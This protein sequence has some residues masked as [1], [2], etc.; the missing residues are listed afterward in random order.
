MIPTRTVPVVDQYHGVEVPDPYRW[1]EDADSPEVGAWIA[2]QNQQ[3]DGWIAARPTRDALR[4]ELA[5]TWNYPRWS[6]PWR[7]GGRTFFF[8]NDGLQN[9][10]VLYVEDRPG[11]E[12]RV[13][14]DPNLLS[15]DGTVALANASVSHD[16][17]LLAYAI[18]RS[19]SDWQ[20]IRIRRIDSGEE[21]DET[22]RWVRF[23]NL[24]WRH[25]STGF[26][27]SRYPEPGTVPPEDESHFNRVFWHALGE[28]QEQDALV[29]QR[30]DDKELG[31]DPAVTDDGRY[32]VLNIWHG[33][34]PKNRIAYRDL[35]AD[36]PVVR[37]LD[38]ADAAYSVVDSIGRTLYVQ[39]DRDAPRGRIVAIDLDHPEPQKWREIVPET[40]DVIDG[41]SL[42]ANRL[43]VVFLH[44]AH[45]TVRTYSLDGEPLGDFPLP[46]VGS[47][48]GFSGKRDE[49]DTFLAFTSFLY[50]TT[51]FHY[52]FDT[53][54][55]RPVFPAAI[56]IDPGQFETRQVFTTSKDGT[57]VPVFVTHRRD[58][59]RDGSAPLLVYGYGGFNVSLTPAFSVSVLTWLSHGGVYAMANLRGGGEYG[60]EWHQAGILTRKQNVFDDFIGAVEGLVAEGYSRPDRLAIRGASNGGLLVGAC[61]V[62]RPDLFGAA[63]AQVPVAD[64]LRYHRAEIARAPHA[65]QFWTPEYGAAEDDE[66]LFRVLLGYSP[67]HN[68]RPAHYPPV[69]ITTADHDDRVVP[70]HSLKLAAA[71]Q[72]A[73]RGPNP[74]LLRVETKAGHGAGK[75]VWKVIEEEA[76][77]LAFLFRALGVE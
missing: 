36:G 18:S 33:T 9:Q 64:M 3:T 35:S 55:L 4:D 14:L 19:G 17:A 2:A 50:P 34:D 27:Y 59:V 39:T 28:S 76:D 65:G 77:V 31:F 47:V 44:D 49:R 7:E 11:A 1:L 5:K 37:L 69:L 42:V 8:K 74:I 51:V 45:H 58:L 38:E 72:A 73:N 68:A 70:A 62:Q 20:E 30:P 13:L 67:Y 21:L 12:P 48:G 43:V 40:S 46:T 6:V 10:A 56:T 61:L 24:A 15:Y 71:L 60:E 54:K 66:A 41:V 29:Y 63:V 16:G 53:A 32:L 22:I 75:P 23:S 26:F 52:D 57:K 25:D